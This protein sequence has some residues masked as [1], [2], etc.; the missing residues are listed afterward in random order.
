M[1]KPISGVKYPAICL[2]PMRISRELT[3]TLGVVS[4]ISGDVGVGAW[5]LVGA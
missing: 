5:L 2:W 3:T 4:A 1:A